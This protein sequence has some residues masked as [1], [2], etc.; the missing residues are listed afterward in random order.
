MH[1]DLFINGAFISGG[2][3]ALPV[4]DP[5]TGSGIA[6]DNEVTRVQVDA[7]AVASCVFDRFSRTTPS[8]GFG[9]G[10]R[11]VHPCAGCLYVR[12]PRH[13]FARIAGAGR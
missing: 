12:P 8:E 9:D 4:L 10:L 2:G 1:M 3:E 6:A 7:A 5:A 11:H 13:G